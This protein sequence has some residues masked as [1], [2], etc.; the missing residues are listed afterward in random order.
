MRAVFHSEARLELAEAARWYNSQSPGLGSNLRREVKAAVARISF[1]PVLANRLK[2]DIQLGTKANQLSLPHLD[3]VLIEGF[4]G[5][6]VE[7]VADG[8]AISLKP[9]VDSLEMLRGIFKFLLV[10]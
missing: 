6:E 10:L 2:R 5:K 4:R 3:K 8:R 7:L 9:F 1:R